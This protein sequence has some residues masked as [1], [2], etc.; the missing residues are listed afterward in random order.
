MS[1]PPLAVC[2]KN[3]GTPCITSSG[4]SSQNDSYDDVT[5]EWPNGC[6]D[7]FE[8]ES[9]N[10][11]HLRVIMTR[12]KCITFCFISVIDCDIDGDYL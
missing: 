4:D 11:D 7:I 10:N 6:L 5:V 8:I 3:F 9:S 1:L 12:I 2:H